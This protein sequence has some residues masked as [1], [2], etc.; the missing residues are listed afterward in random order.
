[1]KQGIKSIEKLYEELI[2]QRE[3]RQDLSA[4]TSLLTFNSIKGNSVINVN[5]DNDVLSY[6]VSDIAHRQLADYLNIP[7]KYYERMLNEQPQLLDMNV[8]CWLMSNPQKRMLRTLDGK[9]RAFLSDRY[10][11][12]DNLELMDH[13]L[14]VIAQ[15]KGCEVIS[16]DITETH[17][18]LKVIN[19]TLKAEIST[20]DVVQAGFVISNSEIGL[21]ALK[22]EPLV[23]RLVC[24]NGMISKDYSHKKYHTGR[25]IENNDN[26]YELYSDA[27]LAADDKA[28]FMKVQ[29]IVSCAVDEAKFHLTVD[30]MR[31]AKNIGTGDDPIKTVDLLCDRYILNRQENASILM[32]FM[33]GGDLSHFGLVNAVTRASQDVKD[34]NR[35][36]ELERIGGVLLEEGVEKAEPKSKIL[37]LPQAA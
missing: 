37:M 6:Y 32:H 30:K 29:D 13:I 22:I 9:L 15:M 14:P 4:D 21:G 1:M 7:F 25:Q 17:L 2:R 23:Y 8:N 31:K 16:Q 12:L 24:K 26:A 11:R 34:Y 19:K 18:Y 28:Y 35:A 27:T 20:G 5:T 3:A 36:T 10:R 33:K